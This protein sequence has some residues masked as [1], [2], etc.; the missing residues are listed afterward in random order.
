VGYQ[1]IYQIFVFKSREAMEQFK[2]GGKA[3]AD[4]GA[5]V[6]A[7]TAARQISFNPYITIYQV[8]QSGFAVQANRDGTGYFVD[9]GLNRESIRKSAQRGDSHAGTALT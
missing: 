2:L 9:P 7:G 8:S 3:G 4:V 5:S 1:E 6:A